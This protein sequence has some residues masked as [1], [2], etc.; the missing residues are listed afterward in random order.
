M[1]PAPRFPD[2]IALMEEFVLP[3]K[4]SLPP[5]AIRLD[6]LVGVETPHWV[7]AEFEYEGST[8]KVA[9][10]TRFEP[11]EIAYRDA[12]QSPP[13]SPFQVGHTKT[14]R[15]LE[16]RDDLRAIQGGRATYLYAY[17]PP[18]RDHAPLPAPATRSRAAEKTPAPIAKPIAALPPRI[19][20]GPD[21]DRLLAYMSVLGPADRWSEPLVYSSIPLAIMDAIWSIGVKYEGVTNV[22]ARY[23]TLRMQQGADAN[24]DSTSA[25]ID[26]V[27]GLGGPAVFADAVSNRQR[28]SSRSGILKADAVYREA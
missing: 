28:T 15:K 16:L 14:Q 25:F 10:D 8:W 3:L 18:S 27:D 1:A 17:A 6:G 4:A 12:K 9:G 21:L 26:W 11:L 13:G 19:G 24:A 5:G 7:M 2:F 20:T 22:I 23:R